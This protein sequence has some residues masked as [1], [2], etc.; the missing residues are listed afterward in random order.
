MK[1]FLATGAALEP[2]MLLTCLPAGF[3]LCAFEV[4]CCLIKLYRL[5]ADEMHEEEAP[6]ADDVDEMDMTL[7]LD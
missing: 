4:C 2:L 1:T 5:E 3:E 7:P 6:D